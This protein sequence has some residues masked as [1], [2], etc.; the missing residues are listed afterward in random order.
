M[1]KTIGALL[2]V[3]ALFAAA[4]APASAAE[5]T[6]SDN[7]KQVAQFKYTGGT[8]LAS[9]G[10]RYIYTG[11]MDGNDN[12]GQDPQKGGM[13]IID[14]KTMKEVSFLHCPGNDNDVE[15]LRPG[16]VVMSFAHNYCALSAGAG[17]MFID[18]K[19]P[20]KPR[21]ISALNTGKS[22]TLKPVPGTTLIYMAGGGY[23]GN[24]NSYGPAIVDWKNPFKPKVVATTKTLTMDCH[25][26]SFSITE[27]DRQLGFC[28]GA[29]G[30]GEVKIW[31]VSDPMV[32]TLI[33]EIVNPAIQYSHYAVAN[34]DG[35]LLAIDDEAAFVAHD[36]NTGQSPYGRVWIYDISDPKLPILQ[37]SWAAP[38][39]RGG[40]GTTNIGTLVGWVSSWCLAHGVDWHPKTNNL[41]VTWFT[42]GMSVL[43]LNDPM[44]PKEVAYFDSDDTLSYS[45]LWHDG[46]LWTNDMARGAEAF[47]IKG[48]K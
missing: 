28:A 32:P 47:S 33:G 19:N 22:H 6:K 41:A 37:S 18:V 17:M 24:P 7:V 44:N 20:A 8:E 10:G 38:A 34:Y 11:E 9:D 12:R 3:G 26:I 16:L 15:F 35:T 4:V 43:D 40:D 23:A 36:C 25:D 31:D 29:L 2:V 1:K 48:L 30:T 21:V 42:A 13:H 46:L 27:E 39:G 45:A 14:S 5:E